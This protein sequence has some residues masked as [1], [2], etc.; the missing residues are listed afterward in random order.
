VGPE[1]PRDALTHTQTQGCQPVITKACH[2][3]C[4]LRLS[5]LAGT[6]IIVAQSQR[7]KMRECKRIDNAAHWGDMPRTCETKCPKTRNVCVLQIQSN[8]TIFHPVVTV[9]IQQHVSA[10]YV[11]HHGVLPIKLDKLQP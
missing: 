3:R 10:L 6:S 4:N 11:G 8:T 1:S 9:G 5:T 2:S 7:T